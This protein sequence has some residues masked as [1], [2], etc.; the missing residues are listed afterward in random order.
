MR[1]IIKE[2]F[3]G[4]QPHRFYLVF[5]V[6]AGLIF[7]FLT[8]PFMVPDEPNH[9]YRAWQVA[10][11]N[12]ISQKHDRRVGGQLPA[13]LALF[14]NPFLPQIW[15]KEKR[16]SAGDYEVISHIEI[17]TEVREFYDF[18]NSALYSPV[19][20][21]PQA[22]GILLA[23][24]FTDRVIIAFYLAR[25]LAMLTALLLVYFAIRLV[26]Q[27]KWLL[28]ALALLPG[29][30]YQ[31]MSLSA[32]LLTNA[33]GFLFIAGVIKYAYPGT[34]VTRRAYYLLLAICILLGCVKSAY[35]PMLFLVLV[36]N[37]S[38]F[39][40]KK[41]YCLKISTLLFVGF[42]SFAFW[43]SV[44]SPLYMTYAEYNEKFR[45]HAALVPGTGM[46]DQISFL[47]ENKI[48]FF[49]LMWNSLLS[50]FPTH[51][52]SYVGTFGWLDTPMPAYFV[53]GAY[54]ILLFIALTD[55][56][57][58]F[59]LPVWKRFYSLGVFLCVVLAVIL[60]MYLTWIPTA[61]HVVQSIQG[62]YLMP[63]YPLFFLAL[64][65][66][67]PMVAQARAMAILMPSAGLVISVILLLHR[68]WL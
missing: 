65:G 13:S 12:M 51:F 25:I 55:V 64:Q 34:P 3:S 68:F 28:A 21:L 44:L 17:N 5:G 47:S 29:I 60:V 50:C 58:P 18:N 35:L 6:A 20:Y 36:I 54:I 62:R 14:V 19:C 52:E 61:H 41:D 16:L 45:G 1:L 39:N 40:G 37:R 32:D 10:D 63:V 7:I 67:R 11:G 38:N 2:F 33:T 26:P 31:N 59:S 57:P 15:S 30:V 24:L 53:Y 49:E 22:A 66:K 43:S 4:L 9:F 46:H 23:R 42:L 48:F 27:G 8:P 56:R